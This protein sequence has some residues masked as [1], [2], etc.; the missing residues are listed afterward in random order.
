MIPQLIGALSVKVWLVGFV[1]CFLLALWW[2]L[3]PVKSVQDLKRLPESAFFS[4][5]MAFFGATAIW[6]VYKVVYCVF[7]HQG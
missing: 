7:I 6:V 2:L 1:G 4:F 5:F 3:S